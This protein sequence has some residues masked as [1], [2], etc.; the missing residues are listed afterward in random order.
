M[1]RA[2][3][4]EGISGRWRTNRPI[5]RATC[6]LAMLT[7]IHCF[8]GCFGCF[9]A[10]AQEAQADMYARFEGKNVSRIEISTGTT[11]PADAF[12]SLL[13]QKENT[14]FSGADIRAS[15]AA[16]QATQQFAKVQVKVVPAAAGLDVQFVLEPSYYVGIAS[17]PGAPGEFVYTRLLQAV[18]IPEQS[19]FFEDLLPE[20]Q[21]A[22][23]QFLK[24]QGYFTAKV[25]PTVDKDEDHKI[26]NLVFQIHAG[27]RAKI[28]DIDIQGISNS[29]ATH[30]RESLH[31]FW[32]RVKRES[33]KPG[34]RYSQARIGKA[35]DYIRGH[36]RNEE[37]LAPTVRLA[38]AEYNPG[39]NRA[40]LVIEVN[41]GPIVSIKVEGAHA[42]KGT[43]RKQIPIYEEN[44]VD[45]DLV[46]EGERNLQSYFESKGYFDAK[47][48]TEYT[49]EPGRVSI[50]YKVD[51]GAKHRV[52]NVEFDGN[53]Y[54]NDLQLNNVLN[55]KP[56][57]KVLAFTIS[58]GKFSDQLVRQSADAI[59]G[60]YK[61]AGFEN[62]SV[63]PDV[64]DY[65]PEVDVTFRIDEGP[66]DKVNSLLLEGNSTQPRRILSGNGAINL[67]PG[68]PY[69]PRLL[70]LDRNRI[71]AVYL[72]KGYLNADFKATVTPET[73][74]KHLFDVVYQIQEGPQ[75]RVNQVVI[76]GEKVA[77]PSFISEV[78][79]Q[80]VAP[81][82][83]LSQG[84]FF[85]AESNLYNLNIF[86]YV[87][88]KPREPLSDQTHDDVLI[89]VHESKRYSMDVG[90][91]IEVIPRSGNIPV[92]A[93]ALPG[94]P[95]I[96]LGTKF[97]TS[98]KSFFGPRFTFDI[99]RNNIRGRAETAN[100]STILSR[101]DQRGLFAYSD[102]RLRG[103]QWNSLF[104][105]SGER[106]TENPLFTARL[107]AASFQVQRYLDA[108]HNKQFILRYSFQRT[109]LSNI[110]IPDLVLPQDQH[111]RLSTVSAEY[112]RDSRDNPL[113][114]HHGVYQTFD[115]DVTPTAF[116]SSA[117]SCGFSG[118]ARFI[119]R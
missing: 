97:K 10:R 32:A 1:N 114:A 53:H 11:A 108:R 49:Q 105:V 44:V 7:L 111:V 84:D 55:I 20:G 92:G 35:L 25:E 4:F 19:P 118:K 68:Q 94:I 100:F 91:G 51:R 54:F 21:K 59:T 80:N 66:Q 36:L 18:N 22:L 2:Q 67:Q 87:S 103:T 60:L 95:P 30:I 62:V 72:D 38:S 83:P 76:L 37:H 119:S 50:V 117:N 93:V 65:E 24:V 112:I 69:S 74:D 5:L 8:T 45:R 89:K 23:E 57:R 31:S 15:V 113:D 52:E 77:R 109:D 61:N 88:V 115:F 56:G 29:E 13:K 82:K 48:T 41:P 116:G 6:F 16:L 71:L 70:Q 110:E 58:R 27:P 75:G 79:G 104:S 99:A 17:F 28:G 39:S 14:P 9:V 106:T 64:K 73:R 96:G 33:L 86:D 42:S 63:T 12:R 102:P 90:G 107:G 81:E 47:V 3:A 85:T 26:A 43:I 98:Q 40:K 101:L 78:T 34:Q 46:D